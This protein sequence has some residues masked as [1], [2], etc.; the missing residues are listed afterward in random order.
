MLVPACGVA[1]SCNPI[2][3]ALLGAVTASNVIEPNP[4]ANKPDIQP[5]GC[6][7]LRVTVPTASFVSCFIT[8]TNSCE[9][10]FYGCVEA[11][12]R[13]RVPVGPHL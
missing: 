13:I 6:K 3:Q 4:T 8:F 1:G 12:A 10:L 9:P 2:A 7:V 5:D 11:R